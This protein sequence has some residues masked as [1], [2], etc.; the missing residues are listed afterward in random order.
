M[1]IDNTTIVHQ[2]HLQE[3]LGSCSRL[4]APFLLAEVGDSAGEGNAAA[5]GF[6]G[7][8]CGGRI[9]A[10]RLRGPWARWRGGRFVRAIVGLALS[11]RRGWLWDGRKE[12]FDRTVGESGQ[13]FV[14]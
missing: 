12:S 4:R 6:D 3:D 8:D 14:F 9:G 7:T 11:L 2:C 13:F 5:T 10:P 1:D